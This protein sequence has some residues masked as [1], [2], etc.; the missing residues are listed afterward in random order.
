MLKTKRLKSI[1]F[2]NIQLTLYLDI[3]NLSVRLTLFLGILKPFPI[4]LICGP[5]PDFHI[6]V[7]AIFC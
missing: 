7:W 3:I 4:M 1:M 2:F 6:I 5:D